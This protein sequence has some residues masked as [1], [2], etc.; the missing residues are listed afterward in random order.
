MSESNLTG[1]ASPLKL[2][3]RDAEDLQTL[4]ACL[5]DALVPLSDIA[6]LKPEKRF[7]MVANRFC[8]ETTPR[9]DAETARRQSETAGAGSETK[10][11][12]R[13]EDSDEAGGGPHYERVNCGVCFDRVTGVRFRGLESRRKLNLLTL[14]AGAGAVTLIFSDGAAIRLDISGIHCH[15]EDLSEPWP[16]RWR[17]SHAEDDAADHR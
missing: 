2:R 10:E 13:F 17:P 1:G 16:T 7:V 11:D 12:A 4:A 3:A 15:L 9:R 5:Q 6:Y 14:E 8:W